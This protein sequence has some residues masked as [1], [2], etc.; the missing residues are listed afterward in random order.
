MSKLA[1]KAVWTTISNT[2]YLGY[3]NGVA[4]DCSFP[5]RD[6]GVLSIIG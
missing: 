6:L 1:G 3:Q 2:E 5:D 4:D